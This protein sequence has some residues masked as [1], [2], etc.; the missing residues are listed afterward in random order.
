MSQINR[1]R[2]RLYGPDGRLLADSW[3]LTGPTYVLAIRARRNGR[4]MWRGRSIE[5]S[6]A[7]SAPIGSTICRTRRR[8]AASLA[9][10]RP[11]N[12]RSRP[13]TKV[14]ERPRPHAGHP[15]RGAGRRWRSCCR[16]TTIAAF[17][18]AVR[19]QRGS[20]WHA[21]AVL[22][23]LSVFLSFS[24]R[25]PSCVRCGVWRSPRTGCGWAG[26]ARSASL[27]CRRGRTRSGC[28]RAPCRT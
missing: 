16:Q 17:T 6:T 19:G 14:R 23:L 25:G 13:T 18:R 2:L 15:R 24:W 3:T 12:A 10:G 8:P 26:R 5:G 27:G 9:R 7:S 4:R 21:M 11:R 1:D 20:F 28:S 22:I